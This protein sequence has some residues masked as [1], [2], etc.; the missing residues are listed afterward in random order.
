MSIS[1]CCKGCTKVQVSD[2]QLLSEF[3]CQTLPMAFSIHCILMGHRTAVTRLSRF[4]AMFR[5]L[6]ALVM[7]GFQTAAHV[8][9]ELSSSPRCHH[10]LLGHIPGSAAA[11]AWFSRQLVPCWLPF[12]WPGSQCPRS[13]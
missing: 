2:T 12:C 8:C 9:S 1:S 4:A 5:S 7:P 10:V 13:T 11:R 3:F 6:T